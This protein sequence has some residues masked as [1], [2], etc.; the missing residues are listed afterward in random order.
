MIAT[1]AT[2]NK[3]PKVCISLAEISDSAIKGI[4]L[5]VICQG[6]AMGNWTFNKN[7]INKFRYLLKKILF[8]ANTNVLSDFIV[9]ILIQFLDSKLSLSGDISPFYVMIYNSKTQIGVP[10]T[11]LDSKSKLEF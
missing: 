9:R 6:K 3:N 8:C 11:D 4:T 7:C 1:F 2:P 10:N 5:I